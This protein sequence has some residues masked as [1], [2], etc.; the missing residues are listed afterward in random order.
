MAVFN[1]SGKIRLGMQE[2]AFSKEVEAE[3]EG[4][5]RHKACALFGSLNGVKRNMI[6][7]EKVEKVS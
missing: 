5:A 6:K 4:D 3:S 2:R 1:V 7:I